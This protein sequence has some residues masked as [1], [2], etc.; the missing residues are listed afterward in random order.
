QADF[1]ISHRFYS[2]DN[3]ISMIWCPQAEQDVKSRFSHWNI[4]FFNMSV[5]PVHLLCVLIQFNSLRRNDRLAVLVKQWRKTCGIS[6]SVKY[7]IDTCLGINPDFYDINQPLLI[8]L[9]KTFHDNT[10]CI[11]W[12][13]ISHLYI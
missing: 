12:C 3:P 1:S 11:S 13:Y 8:N 5:Q 4:N 9:H 7:I 10:S 2:L 6:V